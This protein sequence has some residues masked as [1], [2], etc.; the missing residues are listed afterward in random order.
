MRAGRYTLPERGTTAQNPGLTIKPFC[1]LTLEC[2]PGLI[3]SLE[4]DQVSS[5]CPERDIQSSVGRCP[6]SGSFGTAVALQTVKALLTDTALR[7]LES[8]DY[9]FC[10][11]ARCDV[12]YF[13]AAGSQFEA[14]DLRVLVGHK[15]PY[16]SR[17]LCYC[18][19]E[20][21]GSIRAEVESTGRS[22]AV[23]R[24]R[25][26]IAAGRCACELRNPRGVCCLGEVIAS[27]KRAQSVTA[28]SSRPTP[29]AR[30]AD[31]P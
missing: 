11:D 29:L 30:A 27:V 16:G 6:R 23:E 5:C 8:G 15:L 13:N 19:G 22:L 17:P 12:V 1:D 10:P 24:I 21:D 3:L 28:S 31:A 25:Q 9:R 26:H 18:F 4:R 14:Q 20:S 2:A 7:R